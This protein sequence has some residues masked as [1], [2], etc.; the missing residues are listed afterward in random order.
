MLVSDL[1]GQAPS[2]GLL[3]QCPLWGRKVKTLTTADL[4]AF[5][6]LHV[7][8]ARHYSAKRQV[9]TL[10]RIM[11]QAVTDG[12]M[13]KVPKACYFAVPEVRVTLGEIRAWLEQTTPARR[14][15]IVFGMECELTCEQVIELTWDE[16]LEMDNRTDLATTVA[17]QFPRHFRLPY[18]FWEVSFAGYAQ[19]MIGLRET[20]LDI[21]NGQDYEELMRLYDRAIP[22]DSEADLEDYRLHHEFRP[23]NFGIEGMTSK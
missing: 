20:V 2:V 6:Q 1:L 21:T 12:R 4:R 16:Y 10:M 19:P 23:M 7:G 14:A 15:A 22:I 8:T 3:M 5:L 11:W 9:E 18:V 13:T 17:E